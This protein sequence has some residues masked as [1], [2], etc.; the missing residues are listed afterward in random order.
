MKFKKKYMILSVCNFDVFLF[1]FNIKY[2][3]LCCGYSLKLPWQNNASGCN[4]MIFVETEEKY[5]SLYPSYLD[6]YLMLSVVNIKTQKCCIVKRLFSS[7][8]CKVRG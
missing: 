1:F 7:P 6:L 3:Y 2:K 5:L 8:P 4:I